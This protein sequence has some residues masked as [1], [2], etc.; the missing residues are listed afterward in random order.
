MRV[1]A[2]GQPTGR[3][4]IVS[5]WGSCGGTQVETFGSACSPAARVTSSALSHDRALLA[6]IE[7]GQ[8]EGT[9]D[10]AMSAVWLQYTLGAAAL[11]MVADARRVAGAPRGARALP[12]LAGEGHRRE[13][14]PKWSGCSR[15]LARTNGYVLPD[16]WVEGAW[17]AS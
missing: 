3:A 15:A 4:P 10:A 16:T 2:P 5:R 6:L 8:T 13:L 12:A 17:M 14:A 9:I 7:R 11:G 1:W